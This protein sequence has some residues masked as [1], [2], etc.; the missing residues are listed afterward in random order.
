MKRNIIS[1]RAFLSAVFAGFAIAIH[2]ASATST[3]RIE[4]TDAATIEVS[5]TALSFSAAPNEQTSQ[6]I[7]LTTADLSDDVTV[8]LSDPSSVF[9][10]TPTTIDASATSATVTVTFYPAQAG[11]YTGTI[12]FT[13]GDATAS[14]ALSGQSA[15]SGS[16]SDR[17]LD[18]A[19]YASIDDA[20]PSPTNVDVLYAYTVYPEEQVAWLTMPVY[21]V[22]NNTENW[23]SVT[24]GKYRTTA[25]NASAPFL[26][27]AEYFTSSSNRAASAGT[28]YS[29][30]SEAIATFYVTNTTEVQAYGYLPYSNTNYTNTLAAYECT[31][32]SD[33]TLTPA[34]TATAS[35][36]ES[37]PSASATRIMTLSDLDASKIYQVVWDCNLGYLYEIG[38]K[39]S[40][41]NTGIDGITTSGSQTEAGAAA[42]WFTID[43]IR[44]QSQP[45]QPGIYIHNGKK[46][47]V[48]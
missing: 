6:T 24:Y 34:A 17:Y 27:S 22:A 29:S 26:G 20:S 41:V 47:V 39:T 37:R 15:V 36:S 43:G 21:G 23:T 42:P 38:F 45:A 28:S 46:W 40:T 7:T 4:A 3:P 35:A 48:K 12:T 19:R 1:K 32:A 31:Q 25:W 9:S 11:D 8:S 18:I 10:V 2:A 44:L 14:V 13:S 30:R 5:S 16:A 33:G